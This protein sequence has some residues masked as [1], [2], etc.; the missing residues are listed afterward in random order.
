TPDRPTNDATFHQTGEQTH[1]A[2]CYVA[3]MC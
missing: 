2:E 3:L 1:G